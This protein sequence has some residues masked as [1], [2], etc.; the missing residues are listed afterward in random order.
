MEDDKKEFDLDDEETT[1][2]LEMGT[3]KKS[4]QF[5]EEAE[6]EDEEAENEEIQKDASA[7]ITQEEAQMIQSK[8]VAEFVKVKLGKIRMLAK[9]YIML[10]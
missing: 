7:Q 9:F 8:L 6:K 5:P 1:K 4:V 3:K 10:N 2:A